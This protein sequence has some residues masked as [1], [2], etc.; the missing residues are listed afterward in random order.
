[1]SAK[2]ES[3]ADVTERMEKTTKG[4][5]GEETSMDKVVCFGDTADTG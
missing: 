3:A 1:M 2:K 5:I 4:N